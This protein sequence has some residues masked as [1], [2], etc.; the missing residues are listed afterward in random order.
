[1]DDLSNHDIFHVL[2]QKSR[3]VKKQLNTG[4]KEHNLYIS[5]WSILFCLNKFGVMTQTEIQ[6]YLHVE[7]PTITRTLEKMEKQDWIIRKHGDDKRERIIEMSDNAKTT[8]NIFIKDVADIEDSLL[9]DFTETE[10]NQL[11]Y[12]LNKIKS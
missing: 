5:Q 10:R 3:S 12:L 4:L 7:A 8:F 2:H 9:N 1:M 11:Y 6:T